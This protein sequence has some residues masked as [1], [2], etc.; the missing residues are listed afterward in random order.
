MGQYVLSFTAVVAMDYMWP[1]L[2]LFLF[3]PRMS[4]VI[5]KD[6]KIF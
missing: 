1:T 4:Y 3:N 2:H 5:T 6:K